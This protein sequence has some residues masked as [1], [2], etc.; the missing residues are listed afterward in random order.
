MKKL[1]FALV[2]AL[3]I[4]ATPMSGIVT[5]AKAEQQ[6]EYLSNSGSETIVHWANDNLIWA[7]ND[8]IL[9]KIGAENRDPEAAVTRAEF[10]KMTIA[11]MKLTPDSQVTENI[12]EKDPLKEASEDLK[13]HSIATD[14]SLKTALSFGIITD[15]DYVDGRYRPDDFITRY[16]ATVIISRMAGFVYPASQ[17]DGSTFK[18]KDSVSDV[19]KGTVAELTNRAMLLGYDDGCVRADK[20]LTLAEACTLL[21][22]A[23]DYTEQGID[24]SITVTI[25]NSCDME[26]TQDG[27]YRGHEYTVKAT[28]HATG[29][30][31]PVPVQIIDGIIYIPLALTY[32]K[33][34]VLR[35][36]EM[37]LA[38]SDG[39]GSYGESYVRC[40]PKEGSVAVLMY[41]RFKHTFTAGSNT[42]HSNG[43]ESGKLN[44]I[45]RF[46]L[47][48]E[49]RMLR[50]NLMLPVYNINT[51]E[52]LALGEFLKT[53]FKTNP[54]H[55]SPF[56]SY[57]EFAAIASSYNP[58][59]KRLD[60]ALETGFWNGPI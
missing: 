45:E 49:C 56:S 14:G 46:E 8:G 23:V 52:N 37:G 22:R 17:N 38:D 28:T 54:N 35:A 7:K 13:I 57:S 11:A 33:E 26:E 55:T 51:G 15:D 34:L 2:G 32:E 30:E 39:Y 9:S 59:S 19:Q 40:Y 41:N 6:V 25:R 43:S 4:G 18:Y 58:E 47:M 1:C 10:V 27:P 20:N 50:G 44:N 48:A 60:I 12:I 42:F 5:P 3:L 24:E 53:D 31:L 36:I 16:E 29:Y 21:K